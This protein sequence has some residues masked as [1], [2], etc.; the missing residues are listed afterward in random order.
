VSSRRSA[1]E[2]EQ[3]PLDLAL[4]RRLFAFTAP[5]A[6]TR[7][8]LL[9]LVL[10]RAVQLPVMAW[11]VA[12]VLSGP[13]ARHDPGGTLLGVAGFLAFAL[14]TEVCFVFRM[15]TALQLGEAVVRDLR[16]RVHRH[17][18]RMPVTFF[19]DVQ[20]GTLVSRLTAD[21]DVVR[22]GV[23]DVA[24]VSAVQAGSLLVSAALML[25]YDWQLFLVA[26]VI[27]PA[28]WVIVGHFRRRLSRA[29]REMQESFS[30]VTATL[31]ESVSG[32]REIQSFAREKVNGGLFRALIHDHSRYNMNAAQQSAVFQP[33]LEFNG[34]LFLAIL[35]VVGGYRATTG[36]M[37]L[38]ALVQFLFLSTAV[39]AA[40]PII[41]NQYNQA[42]TAMAGAERVFALLD[43]R[44]EWED[45]PRATALPAVHGRVELRS[46]SFAYVP[47]RPVLEEVSLTAAPGETVALVGPTGS[48]KSTLVNLVAK[49]WLPTSGEI[50][51]DGRDLGSVTSESWHTRIAMVTQDNFLFTGTVLENVRFGR[52]GA[53]EEE[54]RAAVA[55][56]GVLD[57]LD[58]LPRG[59]ETEVGERGSNLSLGQRQL[60]CFAR[61]ML[62]DPRIL[63]LDEATSAV[64][65][66]TEARIQAALGRLLGGRTSFV[67]AH[68]LSTIR[69]AQQVVVLERGRVIERG[70]HLELLARRGRYARMYREF[71]REAEPSAA[72]DG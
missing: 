13:I 19:H 48:G 49:L 61:A 28:L 57:L 18:L 39:F 1:L 69:H 59:L 56:L 25:Y 11:L 44:P 2:A 42:L 68:R 24:F 36:A 34:Q 52:P 51:V 38:A 4:I 27:L 58:T 63:I 47:G 45:D 29:Y 70:T 67:V 10:V 21:I 14:F 16:D 37:D 5:H 8:L 62:A 53:S 30:R 55:S 65:T 40:I 46:V 31:T 72:T 43:R 23:Q 20:V 12:S 50:R 41:G 60:V 71:V 35:I 3:R 33:L 26:L 22:V 32:I 64:D 9:V 15:R 17:L 7:N 66:L 6:R 54:V